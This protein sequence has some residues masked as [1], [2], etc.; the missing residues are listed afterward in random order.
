MWWL[1]LAPTVLAAPE[2]IPEVPMD[3][4]GRTAPVFDGELLDGASG[5]AGHLG[6]IIVEP[7]GRRCVCGARGCA[8]AKRQSDRATATP[9]AR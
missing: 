2:M 8:A 6:H 5:S 9:S 1:A 4:L 7:G 3:L